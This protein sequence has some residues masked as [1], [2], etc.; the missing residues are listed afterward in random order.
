MGVV[1][2][3]RTYVLVLMM[4]CIIVL[5]CTACEKNGAVNEDSESNEKQTL[6]TMELC[7]T[8]TTKYGEVNA[9]T[10]PSFM[11]DYPNGWTVSSEDITPQSELVTL[12]NERGAKIT[13]SYIG[14]KN[15]G[16]YSLSLIH[17]SEPTRL[18]M[19][20]YA[21]FCLKKKN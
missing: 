6:E 9:V 10:Y 18:G 21:V 1:F 4:V 17:I 13:Y 12:T 3:K 5:G 7:N 16:G 19:I 14:I 20:S 11:F 15:P 8:Y 2:M